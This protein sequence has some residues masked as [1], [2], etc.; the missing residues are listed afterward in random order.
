MDHWKQNKFRKRIDKHNF[1]YAASLFLLSFTALAAFLGIYNLGGAVRSKESRDKDK[2][3]QK[4]VTRE[5]H[6]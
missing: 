4:A 5:A 2:A 1:I 6:I 3:C